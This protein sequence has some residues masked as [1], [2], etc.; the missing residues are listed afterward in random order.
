MRVLVCGGRNFQDVPFLWRKLDELHARGDGIALVI[1]GGSDAVA[2]EYYG[3]DY[4]ARMWAKAHNVRSE[5]CWA[6]WDQFGR[7]AGPKRNKEMI[8]KFEPHLVLAFEGG[9]GTANMIKQAKDA[10]IPVT[11]V[12]KAKDR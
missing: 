9:A 11:E 7:W 6:D 12:S 8:D 1:E 2:G 10:G 4:W 3:A 5:T